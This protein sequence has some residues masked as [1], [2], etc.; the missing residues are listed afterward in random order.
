MTKRS[1]LAGAGLAAALVLGTAEV[2]AQDG[3]R[4]ARPL[5]IR[6]VVD[7]RSLPIRSPV[8]VSPDGRSVAYTIEGPVRTLGGT[9]DLAAGSDSVWTRIRVADL[10]TGE[11]VGIDE[12][13]SAWAPSWSPDGSALAFHSNRGGAPGLWVWDPADGETRR[14][15]EAVVWAAFTRNVPRWTP[16]GRRLIVKLLPEDRDLSEALRR[17]EPVAPRPDPGSGVTVRVFRAEP[18][19]AGGAGFPEWLA[20]RHG[21]DLATV[22]VETGAVTR[23]TSGAVPVWWEVSSDGSRVAFSDLTGV[24]G[25]RARYRLSVVPVDGG[26]VRRLPG[27]VR[28][29]WGEAV[30]WSPVDLRLAY[31]SVEDE[32]A[33]IFVADARSGAR[34]RVGE[35][36]RGWASTKPLWTTDGRSLLF[37]D[38]RL[39]RVP[40]GSGE[41]VLVSDPPDHSIDRILSPRGAPTAATSSDGRWVARVTH[42]ETNRTGF[43]RVDP[44]TGELDAV[45]LEDGRFGAG[46]GVEVTADASTVVSTFSAT[47]HAPELWLLDADLRR[48]RRVSALNPAF[49]TEHLGASRL[50]RWTSADGRTLEGS[51]LLP[52]YHR[53]GHRVPLV[54]EVYGGRSGAA[55]LHAF[56]RHRQLLA[57]RGYAVLVPDVPLEVGSPMRDH[58][59]AVVPAVDRV[60][61][62]GIA[63]PERIG[64]MGHSYGG[65][66]VLALLAGSNRFA[67]GVASAAH[68]DMAG[69]FGRLAPDGT[70]STRWAEAG[71]GRMGAP[72]WESPDRYVENSP[73]FHLDGVEAPLLLLHGT[74]DRNTPAHLAGEIFTG[75]RRLDRAVVLA[76]YEGEGHAPLSWSVP[77]QVDYWTRL[78]DWFDEHLRTRR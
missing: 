21:G 28:Q 57:T 27:E 8:R 41:P 7:F 2:A 58:V 61:E 50:V 54:V 53:D 69:M 70:S 73:V 23:L 15:A 51:L 35:A 31:A 66:G 11:I 75:L 44:S 72:P 17:S 33:S 18:D 38:G 1:V 16:D 56:D 24:P 13:T 63:E 67:A 52:P 64:V 74:E 36:R 14:I 32:G 10:E 48:D 4:A 78:L 45:A 5:A 34:R 59:V 20:W 76:V 3:P 12:E 47:R 37:A 43:A 22:D 68:G 60:V 49:R 46:S 26:R 29:T 71:Q 77:N 9:L 55:A 65:Y 42:R 62:L 6:E 19:P 25:G 40:L 39:W 30:G